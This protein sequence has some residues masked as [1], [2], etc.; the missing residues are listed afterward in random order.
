MPGRAPRRAGLVRS[1]RRFAP[2]ATGYEPGGVEDE[3]NTLDLPPLDP[4]ELE[5]KPEEEPEELDFPP[6][7]EPG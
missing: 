4:E 3:P 6:A 5:L 2:G 1:L 7:P